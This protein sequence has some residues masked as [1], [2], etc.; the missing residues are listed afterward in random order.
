MSWLL[1]NKRAAVLQA[2]ERRDVAH[3]QTHKLPQ[4]ISDEGG[5]HHHPVQQQG[6]S[7]AAVMVTDISAWNDHAHPELLSR[8]SP[9]ALT[10][11][12]AWKCTGKPFP[13][14][15]GSQWAEAGGGWGLM[16][17]G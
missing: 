11:S 6:P 7:G 8:S 4:R 15:S 2:A 9:M 14:V 1:I 12:R 5:E 13:G 3:T 10:G 17:F 16:A